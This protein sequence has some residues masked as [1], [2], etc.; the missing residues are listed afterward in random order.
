MHSNLNEVFR[1]W[2]LCLVHADVMINYLKDHCPTISQV[3][4]PTHPKKHEKVKQ[5]V[6][7]IFVAKGVSALATY[8]P[9]G[10]SA[11]DYGGTEQLLPAF[12]P[13]NGIGMSYK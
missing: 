13:E 4:Y 5:G 2:G 12:P 9:I 11:E 1:A 6:H 7:L 10:K 3:Y 8:F